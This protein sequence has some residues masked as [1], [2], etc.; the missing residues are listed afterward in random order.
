[1]TANLEGVVCSYGGRVEVGVGLVVWES[2][3]ATVRP[4]ECSTGEESRNS[5]IALLHEVEVRKRHYGQAIGLFWKECW[6]FESTC[7]TLRLGVASY[8][9]RASSEDYG[10]GGEKNW[11]KEI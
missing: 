8:R 5:R 6:V 3:S 10:G 4:L 9:D 1:M 7:R 2:A 11:R